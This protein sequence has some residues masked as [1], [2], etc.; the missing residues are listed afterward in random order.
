MPVLL[1][2]L[3]HLS[4]FRPHLCQECLNASCSCL[5]RQFLEILLL[6]SEVLGQVF[7]LL[8]T[9]LLPIGQLRRYTFCIKIGIQAFIGPLPEQACWLDGCFLG[10]LE[11]F[12]F[13]IQLV[14]DLQ[15]GCFFGLL[16]CLL[17]LCLH[18]LPI[19]EHPEVALSATV[20]QANSQ[21]DKIHIPN[22]IASLQQLTGGCLALRHLGQVGLKGCKC[23]SYLPPSCCFRCR[24]NGLLDCVQDGLRPLGLVFLLGPFPHPL[25]QVGKGVQDGSPVV[26]VGR[27]QLQSLH[28]QHP[29]GLLDERRRLQHGLQRRIW[30]GLK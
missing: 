18:G 10:Y 25:P 9:H 3:L 8:G 20:L 12:Q 1:K 4:S 27:V 13:L 5:G 6:L 22:C 16:F 26:L 15:L 23:T 17:L 2:L 28:A 24:Q 7:P 21:L 29:Q 19:L 14:P 11:L 30:Q